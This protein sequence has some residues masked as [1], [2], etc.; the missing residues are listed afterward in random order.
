MRVG[1]R[2]GK[3]ERERQEKR[4]ARYA[5]LTK[6]FEIS[7]GTIKAPTLKDQR[8]QTS[9]PPPPPID[10]FPDFSTD[11]ILQFGSVGKSFNSIPFE[12]LYSTPKSPAEWAL[13]EQEQRARN[14]LFGKCFA[15]LTR[16]GKALTL[17]EQQI[18]KIKTSTPPPKDP[19]PADIINSKLQFGPDGKCT[20]AFETLCSAQILR[21]AYETIKSKPGNM[22]R[23]VTSETLDYLG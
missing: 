4:A 21:L 14:L 5:L 18:K 9:T 7:A 23:G 1:E 20:N 12:S 15:T 22:V 2:E 13:K 19:S 10:S 17:I 8:S 11:S 3:W 6:R 16:V